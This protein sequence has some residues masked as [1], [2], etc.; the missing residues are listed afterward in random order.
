MAC[1]GMTADDGVIALATWVPSTARGVATDC[2]PPPVQ[3][4]PP[5]TPAVSASA[6]TVAKSTVV[7]RGWGGVAG[8]GTGFSTDIN[9]LLDTLGR[10]PP[11]FQ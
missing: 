4:N 3:T 8:A 6:A 5:T 1:A 9:F 10:V 7:R 11:L 2:G